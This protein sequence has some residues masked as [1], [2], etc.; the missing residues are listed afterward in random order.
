VVLVLGYKLSLA[1]LDDTPEAREKPPHAR[2][3]REGS[4]TTT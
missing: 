4:E 3:D 2:A 1:W